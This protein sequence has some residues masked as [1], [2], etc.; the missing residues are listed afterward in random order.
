MTMCYC[1]SG[2]E[3]SACCEP[4]LTGTTKAPTAEKLMRSRYSAYAS[5]NID[6]VYETMTP[7]AREGFDHNA[8]KEWSAKSKWLG[9]EII[10]SEDGA[11]KDD[12]GIVE[13]IARYTSEDTEL[14]HHEVA[15]FKKIDGS[16][17]FVEGRLVTPQPIVNEAPKIGRND[18]CSCGSGK[19]F[20]KCCG[21]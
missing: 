4:Y 21:R 17:F 11:E 20:K 2:A 6:Y 5:G 7:A 12:F 13:F 19:K 3:F 10:E 18:P 1:G 15:E 8:A 9:I 16:W 14:E